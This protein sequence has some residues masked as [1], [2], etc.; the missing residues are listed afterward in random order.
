MTNVT[1]LGKILVTSQQRQWKNG[2]K[3]PKYGIWGCAVASK[4][5]QTTTKHSQ[6]VTNTQKDESVCKLNIKI[7]LKCKNELKCD[8][9]CKTDEST[10]KALEIKVSCGVELTVKW[11]VVVHDCQ[12]EGNSICKVV[13]KKAS[14]D[15]EL[16]VKWRVVVQTSP[17]RGRLTA[18]ICQ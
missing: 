10:Y 16:D 15:V 7:D 3:V 9:R 13:L 1:N 5:A 17:T 12:K 8:I 6:S 18:Q 4:P 2:D 11:R 14:C